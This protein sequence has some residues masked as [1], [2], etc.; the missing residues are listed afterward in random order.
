MN[1]ILLH[2][3]V[4]LLALFAA[5]SVDC[6]IQ[7]QDES[8]RPVDWYIGYKFPDLEDERFQSGFAYAY[9]T[10]NQLMGYSW[11]PNQHKSHNPIYRLF[12]KFTHDIANRVRRRF[13]TSRSGDTSRPR[14]RAAKQGWTLSEYQIDDPKSCVSRTLEVA[15]ERSSDVNSI[16]YNDQ[17][18]EDEEGKSKSNARKAHAKGIILI[19]KYGESGIWL[20]HSMP[21]FPERRGSRF[22]FHDN[23]RRFGQTFMCIS[24]DFRAHGRQVLQ[25]LINMQ[26]LVYDYQINEQVRSSYPEISALIRGKK[27]P[28]T[29]KLAQTI[30]TKGGKSLN[31]Y[32]KSNDFNEDMYAGWIDDELGSALYVETWRQGNGTPLN[33]TCP[34]N[35][36]HVNNVKDLKYDGS[37]TWTYFH[38]HSKWAISDDESRGIFCI[39]DSNRMVSQFKRGGGAVC[40]K[41]PS[42]WQLFSNTI[43]DIEPC[44]RNRHNRYNRHNNNNNNNNYRSYDGNSIY[45]NYYYNY[46][47][48]RDN[49]SYD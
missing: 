40:M 27:Q 44:P 19:D 36:Y 28:I 9:A 10:S 43:L 29:P 3:S 18:P 12:N 1:S 17:P 42:C 14:S 5:T 16:F 37:A 21:L 2:A 24:L 7:C 38:D 25:H 46:Y 34:S 6:Q 47:N 30:T 39:G 8:G 4:Y 41:C 22:Q 45:N 49:I 32:S 15:Y 35:A 26:P 20:T 33:S 13:Y 31:I 48:N 23:L 11:R